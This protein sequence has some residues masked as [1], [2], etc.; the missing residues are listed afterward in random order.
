MEQ[1]G[2]VDS[3]LEEQVSQGKARHERRDDLPQVPV[4]YMRDAEHD[5]GEQ[6][7]C[8]LDLADAEAPSKYV[9]VQLSLPHAGAR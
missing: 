8:R 7:Q 6:Q 3:Q 2:R 4:P 5:R 1:Y 9:L